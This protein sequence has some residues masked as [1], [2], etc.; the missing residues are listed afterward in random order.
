MTGVWKPVEVQMPPEGVRC[1]IVERIPGEP[2]VQFGQWHGD[3]WRS[4][5]PPGETWLHPSMVSHWMPLPPLP[6]E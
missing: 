4:F 6:T 5:E 1:L 2:K 3:R